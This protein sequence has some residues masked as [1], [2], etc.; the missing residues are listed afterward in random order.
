[1]H[2]PRAQGTARGCAKKT[3]FPS[4]SLGAPAYAP[5]GLKPLNS[6]TFSARLPFA[7]LRVKSR[8]LTKEFCEKQIPRFARDD[9]ESLFFRKL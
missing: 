5:Q 4:A 2:G 1:M 9:N 8:V 7:A 3:A 6:R